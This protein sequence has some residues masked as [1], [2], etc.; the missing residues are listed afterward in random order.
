MTTTAALPGTGLPRVRFFPRQLL[1]ADD[2]TTEQDYFR[3]KLR[4]HNRF[5]HGWGVVCGCDVVADP[6]PSKLWQVRI[7]PGYVLTPQGDEVL[8]GEDA[9][10]DLMTCGVVSEDPCAFAKP[11]PPSSRA[12]LTGKTVWVAV[13]ASECDSRPV[14]VS[15]AGCG[16]EDDATCEYSRALDAYEFACLTELPP[17]HPPAAV[18]CTLLKSGKGV[19][20]C[21]AE[22]ADPWVVLAAVTLPAQT[23]TRVKN[24]RVLRD[25]RNLYSTASLQELA[26]CP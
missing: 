5:L 11:C 26:F 6:V 19:F 24:V 16:C 9:L 22:T 4:N 20:P 1:T 23:T 7:S 12:A 14:R 8:I 15:S 17:T 18:G 10:F 25:R 21:P 2:L 13:R 3:Q